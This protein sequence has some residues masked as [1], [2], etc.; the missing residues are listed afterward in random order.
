V[1]HPRVVN[2]MARGAT[3]DVYIGRGRCPRTGAR[4]PWGNP[5]KVAEHGD[6]AMTLFLDFLAE[7]RLL[8]AKARRELAGKVLGCWCAGRL[9]VCHGDVLARL[10]D[11]DDLAAIRRDVLA[12]L[13]PQGELFGDA[14]RARRGGD[15]S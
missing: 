14:P 13:R 4:G 9:P 12:V 15:P 6:D 8:V 7:R 11:G 1:S 5:F 2:V 10:A 3:W